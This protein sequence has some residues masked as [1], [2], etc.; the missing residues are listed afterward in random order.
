MKRLTTSVIAL[1][2]TLGLSA[3]SLAKTPANSSGHAVTLCKSQA[4]IAHEGYKRAKA[5]KIK[6]TRG[7]YKIKLKVLTESGSQS[8]VCE[9]AKDGEISYTKA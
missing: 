7:V 9:I 5:S 1:T 3:N 8:T 6:L 4:S 2:L